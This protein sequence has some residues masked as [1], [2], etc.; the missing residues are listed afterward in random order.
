MKTKYI[1]REN[2]KPDR[3]RSPG[4]PDK[5]GHPGKG[6]PSLLL[7]TAGEETPV[8]REVRRFTQ[9][10][11]IILCPCFPSIW[12]KSQVSTLRPLCL[13]KSSSDPG[14]RISGRGQWRPRAA[15]APSHV[16]S[17]VGPPPPSPA[18]PSVLRCSSALVSVLCS[19]HQES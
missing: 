16:W 7:C 10:S 11:V 12:E 14:P 9:E 18:P 17:Q 1:S 5:Q 6:D 15:K 3:Q 19:H 2:V 8:P 4:L 13:P